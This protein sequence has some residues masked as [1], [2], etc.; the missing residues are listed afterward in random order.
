MTDKAIT[1]AKPVAD[2][3]VND[4]QS[5]ASGDERTTDIWALEDSFPDVANL[6]SPS[7]PVTAIDENVLVVLDTNTL[8]LPF[9]VGK[10]GLPLI[11]GVYEKLCKA[12]RLFVPARVIREFIKNRDSRLAEIAKSLRDKSS[13][14]NVVGVEIPPLLE[15]LPETLAISEASVKLKDARDTYLDAVSELVDLI[16]AWRGNDPVTAIYNKLFKDGVIVDVDESRDV[17]EKEWQS[18]LR[19]RIPPGYK[20]GSKPDTGIG[21]FAIWL[22]IL[23]LAKAHKKSLIFVTGDEKADWFIRSDREGIY[24]RPE[25]VDEYRRLSKGRHLHLSKLA[26]LLS[27]MK[28]PDQI[29][30]EVREAEAAA[31]TAAQVAATSNS[32]QRIKSWHPPFFR[33]TAS[34]DYSTNDG[35][36]VVGTEFARFTLTFSKADDTSIYLYRSPGT[37][38]VARAKN[39]KR[40]QLISFD[41]FDSSSRVYNIQLGDLF[42][43]QNDQGQI[44]A[45]RIRQIADDTRGVSH[46]NVIFD[47]GVFGAGGIVAL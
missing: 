7:E 37:P 28:V 3:N 33:D 38:L 18:R 11:N 36:I 25:L 44:L 39:I 10:Q 29:I 19:R 41:Q 32:D 12:G 22:V 16:H 34:F 30:Q 17:I 31:N 40:G 26:D 21:D 27:D 6:F 20:D 23:K 46:D 2:G 5:K 42:L 14:V 45:G 4:A 1:P 43:A 24:P 15:G 13:T 35:S 47:Y 8:L 9:S